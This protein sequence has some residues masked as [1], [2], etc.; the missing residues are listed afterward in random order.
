MKNNTIRQRSIFASLFFGITCLFLLSVCNPWEGDKVSFSISIGSSAASRTSNWDDNWKPGDYL[1]EITHVISITGPGP[2][3]TEILTGSNNTAKFTVV[4]G[5]WTIDVKAYLEWDG[6]DGVVVAVAN[7]KRNIY[8]GIGAIPIQMEKPD[9]FRVWEVTFDANG[10]EF[11][12]EEEILIVHV[13]DGTRVKMPAE[14]VNQDYFF[15]NWYDNNDFTGLPYNFDDPVTDELYLFAQWTTSMLPELITSVDITVVAPNPG[16]IPNTEATGTGNFSIGIVSWFPADNPFQSNTTY[17]ATVTLTANEG[18]VFDTSLTAAIN[19][20]DV[21]RENLEI[22]PDG[23][24]VILLRNFT[25]SAAVITGIQ[26]SEQPNKL[27][28]SHGDY[29]DLS[30]LSVTITFDDTTTEPVQLADFGTKGISTSPANGTS[31]IHTEHNGLPVTVSFN[32]FTVHTNNLTVDPGTLDITGFDIT[33]AFNGTNTGTVVFGTPVFTGFAAGESASVNTTGVTVTYTTGPLVGEH[34]VI[35]NGNFTMSGGNANQANYTIT[36]PNIMGTITPANPVRPDSPGQENVTFNSVTLTP[37]EGGDSLHAFLGIEYSRSDAGGDVSNGTWQ[38]SLVF[39]GLAASTPYN[40]FARYRA[41]ETRNNVSPQSTELSLTTHPPPPE[42]RIGTTDYMTLAQAI[43]AVPAT[44]ASE[45]NPTATVITI[46]RDITAETGYQIQGLTHIQLVAET[47]NDVIITANGNF[48]LFTFVTAGW[49]SSLTLGGTT[50]PN[51]GNITLYSSPETSGTNQRG[52]HVNSPAGIFRMN[53]TAAITGF[54]NTSTNISGAGVWFQQGRFEMFGGSIH[55][56]IAS[57]NGGGV[58]VGTNMT[59]NMSGGEISGNTAGVNGDSLFIT[60]PNTAQYGTFAGG[61]F[62]PVGNFE[63][64]ND[65]I[66]IVNSSE[67]W[68]RATERTQNNRNDLLIV[69]GDFFIP[70]RSNNTFAGTNIHITIRG[71]STISLASA[72]LILRIVTG[73]TLTIDNIKLKGM[74]DAA[75]NTSPLI[76]IQGGNL[77]MNGNASVY[78]N[79]NNTSSAGGIHIMQSGI[80]NMNDGFIYDNFSNSNGGGVNVESGFFIMNGGSIHSNTSSNRGGGVFI[81][82]NSTFHITGGTIHGINSSTPNTA[83]EGSALF[84]AGAISVKYGESGI[85]LPPGP[86]EFT[87]TGNGVQSP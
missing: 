80:F 19:S 53:S 47:G 30:G 14:P 72:G 20:S 17:T 31:L 74:G 38:Q 11:S 66:I 64:T 78:D 6:E 57:G 46:L 37:P 63:T 60:T 55:N 8:Q 70:G 84:S 10:G 21:T 22:A 25:T 27:I 68:Y 81:N 28:Y 18:F 69:T 48:S 4:P 16:E 86:I 83:S 65:N 76:N 44:G 41:D 15:A 56:N 61:V 33:R 85:N 40:F 35:F 52:V 9:G 7:V 12:I 3:Q 73:Q 23:R 43:T 87:I 58:Y 75:V 67:T 51:N 36:P 1:N 50:A 26:I 5:E 62:T 34:P 32:D 24:T 42:A 77:N 79:F 39:T 59:F 29:L 71:N 45:D 49:P 2:Q 54:I 82:N 13:P